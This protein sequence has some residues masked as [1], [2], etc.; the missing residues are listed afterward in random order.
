MK[1]ILSMR[2]REQPK[3]SDHISIYMYIHVRLRLNEPQGLRAVWNNWWSFFLWTKTRRWM[4]GVNSLFLKNTTP[5]PI[6]LREQC[7][8]QSF[9]IYSCVSIQEVPLWHASGTWGLTHTHTHP[10]KYCVQPRE[11]PLPLPNKFHVRLQSPG[12]GTHHIPLINSTL[13]CQ[14]PGREPHP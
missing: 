8:V 11:A 3:Y 13:G 10:N 9:W 5:Y 1:C 14:I 2:S 7:C 4:V 12:D 6:S